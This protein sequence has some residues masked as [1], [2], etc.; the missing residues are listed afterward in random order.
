MSCS[1]QPLPGSGAWT[2][3]EAWAGSCHQGSG[4]RPQASPT[5]SWSILFP[6][7]PRDPFWTRGCQMEVVNSPQKWFSGEQGSSLSPCFP[8]KKAV[9]RLLE[10]PRAAP[11]LWKYTNLFQYSGMLCVCCCR[12]IKTKETVCVLRAFSWHPTAPPSERIARLW[13][14]LASGILEFKEKL[15]RHPLFRP[16]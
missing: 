6:Q 16:P 13:H 10:S 1:L 12:R 8:A 14:F 7:P 4:Q 2:P 5:Q 3:P 11:L 15:P 9:K